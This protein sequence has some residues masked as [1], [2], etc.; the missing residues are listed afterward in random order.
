[1]PDNLTEQRIKF[2]QEISMLAIW[3]SVKGINL[4]PF[5]FYS[6]AEEQAK[7]FKEGKSNC[8][9]T[10]KTSNHQ[11]W[12]AMDIVIID[13]EGQP[14]WN[15]IREYDVLGE[16]W[17]SLGGTWGGHWFRDGKTSFNDVFHFEL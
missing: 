12:T 16:I 9:G 5:R 4:L 10:K 15:P 1:M 2:F 6:T 7:L 17:E 13:K 8:D 14:A 11:T 3:A